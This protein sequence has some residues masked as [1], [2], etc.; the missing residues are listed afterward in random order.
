MMV[1][2][3]VRYCHP[4][5]IGYVKSFFSIRAKWY[6]FLPVV[7]KWCHPKYETICGLM[8]QYA[9]LRENRRKGRQRYTKIC[10]L[11]R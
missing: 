7:P 6:Q 1:K 5:S 10:K 11:M 9:E 8:Q 2:F 3:S 4:N